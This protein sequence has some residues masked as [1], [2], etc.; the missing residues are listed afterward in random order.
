[1]VVAKQPPV[2]K[3]E[4]PRKPLL[5]LEK[6]AAALHDSLISDYRPRAQKCLEV[7]SSRMESATPQQKSDMAAILKLLRP[8]LFDPRN[9]PKSEE[10]SFLSFEALQELSSFVKNNHVTPEILKA[11]KY[12]VESAV[13]PYGSG[14]FGPDY[15]VNIPLKP[16]LDRATRAITLLD[17][18]IRGAAH[19]V[20]IPLEGD[21]RRA[22][23]AL[24]NLEGAVRRSPFKPEY[25]TDAFV[26]RL[27]EM[28]EY[29]A[30]TMNARILPYLTSNEFDFSVEQMDAILRQL[31]MRAAQ[32][33]KSDPE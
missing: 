8:P 18:A 5:S 7:I 16:D 17:V 24:K 4:R 22:A 27:R 12:L 19:F 21:P 13:K 32:P 15:A 10:E 2:E 1:M 25:L 30:T 23:R 20:D 26:S 29:D 28:S 6:E 11:L 14:T 33:R 31:R 9:I 3:T